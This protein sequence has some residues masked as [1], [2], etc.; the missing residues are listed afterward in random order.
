MHIS[1]RQ[2]NDSIARFAHANYVPYRI[3]DGNDVVAVASAAGEL[4]EAAR[5]GKGPGFIEAV[6]FRWYGHVDWREDID[7]GVHRSFEELDK[8]R[9]RDPIRRLKEAM[10]ITG[11]WTEQDDE[12]L[13][14]TLK[15]EVDAAWTKARHAPYP[16]STALL[17]RVY[18][19]RAL[20]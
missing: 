8:W 7:V 12:A 19:Q 2:P 9:Q 13:V 16:G 4:I 3:V 17:E 18:F 15:K 10:L 6:T 20:A 5:L 11:A 14:L 1:T